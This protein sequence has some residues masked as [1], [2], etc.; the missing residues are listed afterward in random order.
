MK[1]IMCRALVYLGEP[2]LLDHLLY[3]P[4]SSLVK[5]SYMPR[6]LR[7]LNLA[8]FGMMAWDQ[9][10]INSELPY[11]YSTTTLPVFDRNLKFLS[12]KIKANCFLGHVRGVALDS[13]VTIHDHNV[14]P[15]WY[16]GTKLALAHNGDLYHF[17]EMRDD[18]RLHIRPEI[19]SHISGSTDSEWIY[20]VLLSQL[21]D[22]GTFSTSEEI[23]RAIDR[24]FGII[25]QVRDARGISVASS[26]NLFISDGRQIFAVRFC[27]DFGRYPVHEPSKIH[28]ANLTYLSLWYTSGREYGFYDEEWQMVGGAAAAD[29]VMVASEPLTTDVAKWLEVPEYS[30]LHTEQSDGNAVTDIYYVDF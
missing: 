6:M 25:G 16:S 1:T 27:F 8:G 3:Q 26:A 29:S 9:A 11:R 15:F 10:S 4:D 23:R 20:A 5:Q 30:L 14:H 28:E 21:E 19:A 13:A 17:D 2:V 7:M 18:L 22:P 24:T 12:G